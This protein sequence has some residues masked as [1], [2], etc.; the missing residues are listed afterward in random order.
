VKV[1]QIEDRNLYRGRPQIAVVVAEEETVKAAGFVDLARHHDYAVPP[2][3]PRSRI[4]RAGTRDNAR[5]ERSRQCQ[6]TQR[7]NGIASIHDEL[8][9][10]VP[11]ICT[12]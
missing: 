6:N 11:A 12:A 3:I 4:L 8:G 7:C 5:A 1:S 9:F 10:I 2:D